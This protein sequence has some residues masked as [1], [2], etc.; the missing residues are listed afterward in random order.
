VLSCARACVGASRSVLRQRRCRRWPVGMCVSAAS[1]A[2][3]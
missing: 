3:P 1:G 2:G